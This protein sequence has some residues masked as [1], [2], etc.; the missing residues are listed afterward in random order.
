MIDDDYGAVGGMRI[1]KGNR[2]TRR[3]RAPGPL[4]PPQIF[5]DETVVAC[6]MVLSKHSPLEP[7]ENTKR[8]ESEEYQL[9][10]YNAV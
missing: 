9:P 2:N 7:D 10:G 8:Q 5:S 1:G 4:F 3:K 6:L